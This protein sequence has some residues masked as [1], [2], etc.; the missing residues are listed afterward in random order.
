[1]TQ[2]TN[3][4]MRTAFDKIK[5]NKLPSIMAS[6]RAREMAPANQGPASL[7]APPKKNEKV[8]QMN[9]NNSNQNTNAKPRKNKRRNIWALMIAATLA[10]AFLGTGLFF[11]LN[12]PAPQQVAA[13][14]T[15][16]VNPSFEIELDDDDDTLDVKA[17][18]KD[19]EAVLAKVDIKKKSASDALVA[20]IDQLAQDGYLSDDQNSVL[21]SVE[22]ESNEKA[23]ALRESLVN[24]LTEKNASLSF[25]LAVVSKAF[26]DKEAKEL[27]ELARELNVSVGKAALIQDIKKHR[28]TVVPGELADCSIADLGLLLSENEIDDD[29]IHQDGAEPVQTRYLT[30]KEAFQRALDHLELTAGDVRDVEIELEVKNGA[31]VYEVEFETTDTEYDIYVDAVD[32]KIIKMVVDHND[33]DDDDDDNNDDNDDN[34]NDDN[35]DDKTT[36]PTGE[37]ISPQ[38]AY[39][40]ALAHL[41]LSASDVRK[42]EIDLDDDDDRDYYEIDIRT[43]KYEYEVDVDAYSGKILDVEMDRIDDDNDDDNDDDDDDKP[44]VAPTKNPTS[45]PSKSPTSAPS[46]SPTV[47]PSKSRISADDAYRKALAYLGLTDSVVRHYEVDFE[48]DDGK[49]YYEV[50][51]KTSKYE[52]EVEVDAYSGKILDVDKDEVD[53]DDDDD[54]DDDYRPSPTPRPTS[55]PPATATP[56]PTA[57]PTSPPATATPKPTAAPTIAPTSPPTSAVTADGAYKKLLDHFKLQPLNVRNY[58]VDYDDEG[59]FEVEIKTNDPVYK[60]HVYKNTGVMFETEG[61]GGTPNTITGVAFPAQDAYTKALQHL[62]LSDSSITKT[63][64]KYEGS[65]YKVILETANDIDR[66]VH[67]NSTTGAVTV[68]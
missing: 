12:R 42:Y 17:K 35:D 36:Q 47:A 32:G 29:D 58:I 23:Q 67:V 5:P 56:K 4:T 13:R 20:I 57:A 64:V 1:M 8:I 54:D 61:D 38:D 39:A 26:D 37:M 34:D 25:E 7:A 15:L 18:S 19:A 62:G 68:Q 33:Y 10:V 6:I 30:S 14:V 2:E 65:Y 55:A 24:K 59:Y 50:D 66:T 44:S 46:K 40:R 51:I 43:D 21:L 49:V 45:A 52:Y 27:T 63:E 11:L 53:D 48:T 16:D 28:P 3:P 22:A 60:T 9:A 41:K 31:F